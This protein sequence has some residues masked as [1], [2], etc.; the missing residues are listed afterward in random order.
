MRCG[1]CPDPGALKERRAD[2]N[3][4]LLDLG[5]I[6]GGLSLKCQSASGRSP[7]RSNGR[8]VLDRLGWTCPEPGA[9][10]QL[11]VGAAAAELV[12]QRLR[13]FHYQC[14][15]LP[16]GL[17]AADDGALSGGDEDPPCFAIAAGAGCGEM[18]PAERL[19]S[20]SDRVEVV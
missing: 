20:R 3:D 10:L 17:G 14:F 4:K 8:A 1:D 11:L 16:D 19:T 7:Y 15:E 6:R 2:A 18:V 9:T 12:S 5:L 13:C